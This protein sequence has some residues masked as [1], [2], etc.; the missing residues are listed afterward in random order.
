MKSDFNAISMDD[1]QGIPLTEMSLDDFARPIDIGTQSQFLT[2]TAA[3][4]LMPGTISE[5]SEG[6]LLA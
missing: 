2:A 3:T 4:R 1:V 6:R 5:Y